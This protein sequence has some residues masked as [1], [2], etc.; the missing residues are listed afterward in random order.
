M[1][2]PDEPS[3]EELRLD[4][5]RR[6]IGERN[7]AES[8]EQDD[9]AKQH[10]RRAQKSEYLKEKLEERAEAERKAEADE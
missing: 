7:Q 8:A 3:T 10:A 1:G 9:E 6:E 5:A 2:K 4:Q